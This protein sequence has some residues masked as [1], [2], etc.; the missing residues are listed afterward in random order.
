MQTTEKKKKKKSM[1][2]LPVYSNDDILE[3]LDDM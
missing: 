1:K 2:D 3:T